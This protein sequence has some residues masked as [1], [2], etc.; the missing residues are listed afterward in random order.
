MSNTEIKEY[1]E[2]TQYGYI[3]GDKVY[4]K[5]YHGFQDREIGI[6]KESE[7]ESLH[8]FVNRFEM[9]KKKVEKV[10]DSVHTSENKGSYLMK[11]IHMRAYL[12]QYNGLGNFETLYNAI[13]ELED[14]INVYIE[15]NRTKNY[16]IKKS[17]LAEIETL[18]DSTDWKYASIKI[19]ELKLNWIKTGSAH[20]EAEEELSAK[21]NAAIDRFFDRRKDFFAEQAKVVRDR[22]N[23]YLQ[24]ID[25]LRFIN[26]KGGGPAFTQRVKTL[27][28]DWKGIGRIPAFKYR[29]LQNDFRR[30][31]QNFF[32]RL[33]SQQ[34]SDFKPKSPIEIKKELYGEVEQM[35]GSDQSYNIATIKRIQNQWKNL[36]KLTEPEDRELNLKFRIACNEIFETHFLEKTA[37]Y[38]NTDLLRR[39]IHEQARIK[40]DLLLESIKKDQDELNA[41]NNKYFY[42]LSQPKDPNNAQLQQERNNYVN[43]LKTKQRILKKLESQVQ[44]YS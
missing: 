6:V 41:F 20:K 43:R 2:I 12:A 38:F 14:G 28:Q 27:Q 44:R 34:E 24:M 21:F 22:T 5:G 40:I 15:K 25:E 10:R 29:K 31:S 23:R 42:E 39:P 18:K 30:E 7:E 8:Y 11:L 37:S 36:G 26:R 19:K 17:L 32:F 9:A 13:N 16:D 35:I 33:K 4:L 1:P 3:K